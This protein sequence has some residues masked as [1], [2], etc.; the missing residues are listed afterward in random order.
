MMLTAKK[1]LKSPLTYP[2]DRPNA[3]SLVATHIPDNV[4]D[5]V[6]PFLG[7]GSLEMGLSSK[8]YNIT[9][10]TEY[11]LLY[12]FW[13]CVIRNPEKLY[14]MASTFYPMKERRL[15]STLQKKIYQPDDEF[16]RSALFYVLNHC[17]EDGIT[18]GA[19]MEQGTPRFNQM[20]LNSLA[21]FSTSPFEVQL[22]NYQKSFDTAKYLVCSMPEYVKSGLAASVVI[23]ERPQINH[24]KFARLIQESDCDGWILLY[25]YNEELLG[26]Y[27]DSEYVFLREGCRPTTNPAR[28]SEVMIIGS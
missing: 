24:K 1:T 25:R 20:R 10:F 13:D 23:P 4:S 6:T 18:T 19:P 7:G 5:V 8:G 21:S 14:H 16:M 11:R 15:F 27:P 2:N 17:A 26:L 9:A 28:A 22:G 12:D 3:V